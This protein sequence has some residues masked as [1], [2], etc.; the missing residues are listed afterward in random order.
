[1]IAATPLIHVVPAPR[2][3]VKWAGG[4]AQLL[5]TL[6]PL[7]QSQLKP[8]S[9][10]HEPFLGGGAVFFALRAAGFTGRAVLSDVNADLVNVYRH[11]AERVEPLIRELEISAEV[12]S[13]DFF[14]AV[15]EELNGSASLSPLARAAH[16]VYL[17]KTCFNGL[18]RVNKSGGFN[19][20]WGKYENPTICDADNL[21]ACSAALQGVELRCEDF[22][23]ALARIQN[24]NRVAYLDPPY[25]PVS[26][27]SNFVG[28]GKAGFGPLD[29]AA[30]EVCCQNIGHKQSKFVL[31]NADCEK[32]R[33]LYHKWNVR[34]V[35]ARRNV[36]SKGGKRGPVGE[37]LVTNF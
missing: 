21:R 7:I 33:L 15:R 28:Y 5:P 37:L 19:V 2:P 24:P 9:V 30:L 3:F 1:M 13:R 8:G 10:Y 32:T 25:V 35:Q 34:L 26:K 23:Y 18:H 27:T 14:Y 11:V 4:K 31:S 17:N 36:N 22:R 16:F 20:P 6:L 29:Q 12:N